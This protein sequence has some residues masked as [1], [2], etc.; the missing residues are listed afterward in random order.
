M[1]EA[2]PSGEPDA[3]SSYHPVLL[4][5]Y[6]CGV[7]F[8]C[9]FLTHPVPLILAFFAELCYSIRL[10][11]GRAVRFQL[12]GLLPVSLAVTLLN[13]LLNR[14]GK[15]TL[16]TAF[17]GPITLESLAFGAVYALAFAAAV[18]AFSCFNRVMTSDRLM[19][20]FGRLS[21]V[22]SLMFSLTLRFVPRYQAQAR[23]LAEAQK[24]VGLDPAHGTVRERI[25][26]GAELVSTLITWALENAVE[27]ADSM[28]ARGFGLK[29]RTSFSVFVWRKRDRALLAVELASLGIV[30]LGLLTGKFNSEYIPAIAIAGSNGGS[31]PF[32]AA[33]ALFCFLPVLADMREII[34]WNRLKSAD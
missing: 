32:Y 25:R 21:P 17:G 2:L 22:F 14:A 11:G 29:G 23:R 15:T 1:R 33:C 30:L 5:V 12:L 3:F 24:G 6:F 28:K 4:L 27:S 8:F 18:T 16:F 26:N 31:F 34:I 20:L 10:N 13:P 7:L 9:M 19:F